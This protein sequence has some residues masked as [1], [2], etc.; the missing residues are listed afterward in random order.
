MNKTDVL[1]IFSEEY[2]KEYNERFLLEPFSKVSSDFELSVLKERISSETKWL[3]VGCG[4]GYFLS[5]FPGIER[6]GLDISPYML[7]EAKRANPDAIFLTEG[8]CRSEHA[9]WNEKWT[10]VSC[11]WQPYTY[12]DSFAEFET[13]MANMINWLSVG[14]DL[15]IPILDMEDIRFGQIVTYEEKVDKYYSGKI[16]VNGF[17]WTWMEEETDNTHYCGIAP[18]TEH[19]IRLLSPFFETVELLRYPPY[20]EGWVSRKAVLA[21]SKFSK[22]DERQSQVIRHAIPPPFHKES[23]DGNLPASSELSAV[24]G[25]HAAPTNL[26]KDPEENTSSADSELSISTR[27][28]VGELYRR[29]KSGQLFRSVLRKITNR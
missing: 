15:I 3:D 19:V 20:Y 21:K 12:F 1:N 27:K 5:H 24:N 13:L 17:I 22:N 18:H 14:G 16:Q 6:A 8:D 2:A 4:T 26:H 28:L 7:E 11:L 25:L 9:E 10:F 29:I 23:C